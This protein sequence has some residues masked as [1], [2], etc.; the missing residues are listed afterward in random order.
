MSEAPPSGCNG[1][2][3]SPTIEAKPSTNVA[4][5]PAGLHFDLHQPQKENEDPE[6]SAEADLRDTRVT[7]PR[8]LREPRL[9]RRPCGL[10]PGADRLECARREPD[11][12]RRRTGAL[13][14]RV[15]DR[16]GR[17]PDA[18]AGSP[19]RGLCLSGEPGRNPFKSLLAFYIALEDPQTGIVI[20]VAAQGHPDPVTG[21]L[22]TTV[23]RTPQAPVEDFKFDFFEGARA[24]LR[25]PPACGTYATT[26]KLTPWTTPEGANA[27]P[28]DSFQITAG[29]EG[30]CPSG[31]L[32]PEAL[33]RAG[34]SRRRHLQSPSTCA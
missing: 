27:S 25:T 15:Q 13:P 33:R 30:P 26:T 10:Q 16:H 34:Q 6:G 18:T 17:G 3:F 29:P 21:Q 9:R 8:G 24:S 5:A 2:D 4:D 7:V 11:R 28:E 32:A 1:P 23:E 31:A 14:R 20:K 12:I 22:S 19:D